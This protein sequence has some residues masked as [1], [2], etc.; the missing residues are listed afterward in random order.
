MTLEKITRRIETLLTSNK[1]WPIIVD[2]SNKKD[3]KNFQYHFSVKDNEIL[4][5]GEFCGIDSILKTE[6]LYARI[7]N[8]TGNT[9]LIHLSAYLKMAGEE[10]LKNT[11]KTILSKSISGHVIVV[12]YQ[13]RNYLKFSDGRFSERG[14]LVI[15]DGDFDESS[16]I[17]MVAPDLADA[18]KNTNVGF[19]KIGEA[20]ETCQENYIYVA[21]E[22]NKKRFNKSLVNITQLNNGYEILCTKDARIKN[23]PE[24]FGEPYRWNSLLK[25]LGS[26]SFSYYVEME[27]GSG[28]A[29]VECIKQY[30]TYPDRKMWLYYISICAL[31]TKKGSYLSL[32]MASSSSYKDLPRSLFRAILTVDKTDEDFSRFY[33]ERKEIL[34]YYN[35]YLNETVD[36]CKIVS[37]KQEDA[38]YYL[39]NLTKSEKEKVIEW[40]DLYGYKY[41][42]EKLI[43]ILKV[44]YP[45]LAAYL[46]TYRFKNELLDN[47]FETY[48]Y[49]KV[50]NKILPVF[51]K[52]VEK[53]A[54]ELGFVEALKPRTQ[55]FDKIDL[56]DAHT[57]FFDALG[58]E[59]LGFIQTKC[60]E[61]G[62][63]ANIMCGRSELPSLTCFNKEFVKVCNDRMCPI[64][65]IKELDTIKHHG[66]DDFDYRT[67]KTPVYLI[68]ELEIIDDLLKKIQAALLAEKYKKAVIVSDHGASRLAVLHDT[69]NIWE[70]NT[71]GVHSGRCCPKNEI[72]EKPTFA[73]EESDYWILANYD[74]FKGSRKA[75]VEV[76]GG[77]SI[78]EVTVPIIEI[79]RKTSDIEAFILEEYRVITLAAKEIPMLRIFAGIISNNIELKV[80]DK[81]YSATPTEDK[82]IYEVTLP[83]C[84]KKGIYYADII[85]GTDVMATK[86]TFTIE[87]KG[88]KEINLFD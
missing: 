32:A 5:A 65:E 27:F 15:V 79:T 55:L 17:C 46:S 12:T 18:F 34:R 73:I 71:K 51:E 48:K 72:D 8:N 36:Y 88:M 19:E 4:S 86:C 50:I 10:V 13:C 69:E 38:I 61:Y 52:I 58:A 24:S 70:M 25:E 56:S 31:G 62:L 33:E 75:N 28:S 83:D 42:T 84:T 54:T 23:V 78:E 39:T 47:Y 68:T 2:F 7:E 60:N 41:T 35:K 6:E 37:S 45:D 26:N 82:Y 85:N 80:N 67:T 11:L 66:E 9:F 20:F 57:F 29:I 30:P 22:I 77:A 1:R 16:N 81:Y 43:S 14:Q 64:S 44:V 21:T 74:R 49:Q 3:L 76:H 53:Q 87:K 63:S 59:Y 40:L